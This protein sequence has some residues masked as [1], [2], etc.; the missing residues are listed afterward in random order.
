MSDL[1]HVSETDK[2][3]MEKSLLWEAEHVFEKARGRL[4]GVAGDSKVAFGVFCDEDDVG[5][6]MGE[7]WVEILYCAR[8][9]EDLSLNGVSSFLHHEIGE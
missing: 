4:E 8:R 3:E 2:G 6:G 9:I 7:I 5:L 1:V